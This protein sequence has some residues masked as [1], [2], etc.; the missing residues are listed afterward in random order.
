MCVTACIWLSLGSSALSNTFIFAFVEW[1]PNYQ[2]R[3]METPGLGIKDFVDDV[4]HIVNNRSRRG[5]RSRRRIVRRKKSSKVG[6]SLYHQPGT[7]SMVASQYDAMGTHGSSGEFDTND[8]GDFD[9]SNSSVDDSIDDDIIADARYPSNDQD[10]RNR[11]FSDGTAGE[12]ADDELDS[13]IE[14]L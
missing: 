7:A 8:D 12:K 6:D 5:R 3:Q 11:T 14:M 10:P 13:D 1:E 2:P 4:G 9:E